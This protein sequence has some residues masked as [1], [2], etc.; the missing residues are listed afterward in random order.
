MKKCI[1]VILLLMMVNSYSQACGS[2]IFKIKFYVLNEQKQ[3]LTYEIIDLDEDSLKDFMIE[4]MN[5]SIYNGLIINSELINKFNFKKPKSDELPY[6]NTL[7]RKGNVFKGILEF[8]TKE[9]SSTI[10][11]IKIKAN[12]NVFY[13]LANIFGGCNRTTKIL[14]QEIPIIV[15]E[16]K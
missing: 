7:K 13:I 3:K 15:V 8:K 2:G 10:S 4:N 5:L 6:K 16:K 1:V 11:L 9:L 14:L 12:Q